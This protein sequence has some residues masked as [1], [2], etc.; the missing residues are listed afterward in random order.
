MT[1]KKQPKAV[2]LQYEGKDAPRVIAKGEYEIARQIIEAAKQAGIPLQQ[3]E[4]LTALLSKVKLNDEI[5]ESLYVAVA[6][7]LAYIYYL[8]GKTP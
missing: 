1:D 7:L 4:E 8:N 3:D 2:A 5:P 6:Q